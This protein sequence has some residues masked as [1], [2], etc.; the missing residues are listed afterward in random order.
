MYYFGIELEL[1]VQ[2]AL[3]TD[4]AKSR[5]FVEWDDFADSLRRDL[6]SHGV[7]AHVQKSFE[8]PDYADWTIT[9]DGSVPDDPANNTWGVEVISPVNPEVSEKEWYEQLHN[10]W[11]LLESWY[12][13]KP[14]D[15][16]GTHVHL[17]TNIG[18]WSDFTDRLKCICKCIVYFERCIDSIM[19]ESRRANM[20]C[21]SNRYN[22]T[23]Q[24]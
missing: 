22:P 11:N 21:K 7:Q 20:Y 24:S 17:S 5:T 19:P 14:L 18:W 10:L 9:R 13:V 15:S 12:I 1:V 4:E 16:C 6:A 23:L 3:F 8:A 2:P